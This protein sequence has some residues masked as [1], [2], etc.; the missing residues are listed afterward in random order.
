MRKELVLII[1]ST[2]M[3]GQALSHALAR[4]NIPHTGVARKNANKDI[5]VTKPYALSQLIHELNPTM[6][7]NAAALTNLTECEGN[8]LT[9]YDINA[10]MPGK[11]AELCKQKNIYLIQISTDHYYIH[12]TIV[13]HKETDAITLVNEYAATKYLGECLV[14]TNSS[15]LIIRTNI[16]G[17]RQWGDGKLTFVESVIK[18][19][20]RNEHHDLFYDYYTSSI[21]VSH[22]A[23][24]LIDFIKIKPCGV[25]NIGSTTVASKKDFI[26][27]IANKFKFTFASVKDVSTN[28]SLAIQRATNLGLNVAKAESLLGYSLPDID[29]VVYSLYAH[30]VSLK[31]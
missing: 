31:G 20:L 27:A 8:P 9:A 6:I 15:S 19:F 13:Q 16:V 25:Y 24:V 3:L 26:K 29:K 17:F 28:D 14:A 22:F 7:I 5:D 12:D 2:G 1:G 23:K 30:Y 11:L 4:H 10:R 21:D 18:K